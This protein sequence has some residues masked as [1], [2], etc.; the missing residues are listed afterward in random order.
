MTIHG[1][2]SNTS[3]QMKNSNQFSKIDSANNLNCYNSEQTQSGKFGNTAHAS[4]PP[5]SHYYQKMSTHE[6][7]QIRSQKQSM[8]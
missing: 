5:G 7:N 3:K 4:P 6:S 2:V 8:I 1:S